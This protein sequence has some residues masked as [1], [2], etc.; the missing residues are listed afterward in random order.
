MDL[1]I[2]TSHRGG[3]TILTPRGAIDLSTIGAFRAV[4][5]DVFLGGPVDLVLDLNEVTF[6]DSTGLGA[7]ISA[8]RR[9]HAFK[10]SLVLACRGDAVL[11]VLEVTGLDRVFEMVPE[12]AS[13]DTD[14][15]MS[16]AP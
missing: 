5:D 15:P 4:L 13:A 10:G 9:S 3:R 16:P 7:L 11:R 6:L 8:R 12:V 2:D 1:Q 14:A